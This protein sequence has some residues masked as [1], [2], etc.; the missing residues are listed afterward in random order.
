MTTTLTVDLFVS[1]DGF[2]G[3]DGLPGYFGYLGP[4]LEE[5]ITT[6]G[7]APQVAIMGRRTYELLAALPEEHR[8]ESWTR[9]SRLET[10]VFSS[11]LDDDDVDWPAARVCRG[12]LVEEI[13]RLKSEA[14]TPLRTTGS[15]SVA[16]QLVAAGLVDR[17]RLVVFPLTA[18]PAGREPAFADIESTELELLGTR[19]L[20]GRLLLVEYRPTGNDIP[21]A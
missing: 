4:D 16:R 3:S 19:T 15:L 9:M 14:D 6:E 7:K 12:D 1:V 2:A 11:T 17:L 5:W 8:D 10:V 21:R 18:G 20:D 13:G